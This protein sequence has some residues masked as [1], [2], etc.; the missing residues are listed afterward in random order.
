MDDTITMIRTGWNGEIAIILAILLTVILYFLIPAT[1][2]G[3]PR[4]V[5]THIYYSNITTPGGDRIYNLDGR[6]TNEGTRGKVV[7]T[8]SLVNS[9]NQTTMTN[10]SKEVFMLEGE[11]KSVTIQLSGRAKEPYDIHF[12]AKR[13]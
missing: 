13:K 8:A 12:T 5:M 4:P 6:V 3:F 10:S 11:E 7:V 9:S 1:S 2:P